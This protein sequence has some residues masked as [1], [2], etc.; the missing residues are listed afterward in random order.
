MKK[1]KVSKFDLEQ[2]LTQVLNWFKGQLEKNDVPRL[3]DVI[4]YAH[5]VLGYISLKRSLIA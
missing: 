5:R 2:Q 1:S 3:N 4:D